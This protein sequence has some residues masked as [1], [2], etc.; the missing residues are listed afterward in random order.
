LGR[1]L[2]VDGKH[3]FPEIRGEVI[4]GKDDELFLLS[5]RH[6]TLDY[7][8]GKVMASEADI[9]LFASTMRLRLQHAE[10]CGARFVHLVA[11]DKHVVYEDSFPKQIAYSLGRDFSSKSTFKFIYPEQQLRSLIQDRVYRKTDSHWAAAGNIEVARLVAEAF[12][13]GSVEL[14]E[15]R[16]DLV[17]SLRKVQKGYIGDL[18]SKLDPMQSEDLAILSPQWDVQNFSNNVSGN[19]GA[20][21]LVNSG[22]GA[23]R[24]RLVIFGD[25]FIFQ[26]LPALSRYFKEI[27]CCRTRNYH[28]EIVSMAR[29]DFVLTE[30]VERYLSDPIDDR[31]AAPFF[32]IPHNLG[33]SITCSQESANALSKFLMAGNS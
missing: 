33:R 5:S 3:Q 26:T 30:N 28:K 17:R 18:G 6:R 25:S 20:F 9:N 29:P 13:F 21:Q 2:H 7:L 16:E 27:L 24:G 32:M 14:E 12:G 23:S 4:A 19:E 22:H 1:R 31:K 10:G 11:P 15:G 8:T